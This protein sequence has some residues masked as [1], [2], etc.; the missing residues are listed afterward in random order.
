[1]SF[2]SAIGNAFKSL[3]KFILK[4]IGAA[5]FN[6]LKDEIVQAALAYVKDAAARGLANDAAREYVV[7]ALMKSG[8]PESLARLAV[9]LAVQLFKKEIGKIPGEPSTVG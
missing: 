1:M 6:G 8:V 2:L 3:G 4:A 5:S 7:Q 9:E